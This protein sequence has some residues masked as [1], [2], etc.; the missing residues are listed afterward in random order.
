M[1]YL[2]H[3][4]TT[5]LDPGVLEAMLPHMRDTWGNPSSPHAKGRE[6]RAA[7][8]ESRATIAQHIGV[9]PHEVLFVSSGS[10][11]NSLAL[12]GTCEKYIAT[13]KQPGRIVL[14]S[15][16]H[17]CSIH[18][19]DKLKKQGWD[20]A[21]IPVDHDG[22]VSVHTI[23]ESLT[24]DTALVS[25]QWANNEVGTIQP[26]EEIA[27]LCQERSVPFHSDAVQPIGQLP[28]PTVLPDMMS[29][30][31][32]KFYGPKGIGTLIVREHIKLSP[33]ILGGGQEYSLRAGTEDT[34]GIVGMA[35]AL[36]LAME[37]QRTEAAR[38][39][40]LR[41]G[42]ISEL[43]TLP[44]VSL[45]GHATKRLPNNVNV[46]FAGKKAESLVVQLDLKGICVSTGA[47]C[48]TG[49]SEPSHVLEAMG[50]TPQEAGEN[51]R[52]TLGR[53]TT[54]EELDRTVEVLKNLVT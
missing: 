40:Q 32:H 4:A 12:F 39:T 51:L 44:G 36:T 15:T 16:E 38:L 50:R 41:E 47:A 52:L 45:N 30:A 6:A 14:L 13:H 28:F 17:S 53:G 48:V 35:A 19:T 37:E 18:A 2:D 49:A 34:P 8:D 3:A 26:I 46:R 24:D 10:E 9:K 21:L 7:I 27:Q 20:V 29:M 1:I 43:L 11:A 5:P 31:A 25:I 54:K 42:F 23:K 33:Q 22:L